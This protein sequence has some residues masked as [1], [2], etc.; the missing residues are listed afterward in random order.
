MAL[1]FLPTGVIV[2]MGAPRIGPVIQRLGTSTTILFAMLAFTIGYALFLRATP[3][4]PYAEFLLP[5]S[6]LTPHA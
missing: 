2:V 6:V 1:A 4:M 3:S 5:T